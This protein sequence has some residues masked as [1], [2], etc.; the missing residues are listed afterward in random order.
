MLKNINFTRVDKKNNYLAYENNLQ[1]L[2]Y[3]IN[4]PFPE[5][6]EKELYAELLD[7]QNLILRG[8]DPHKEILSLMP[9]LKNIYGCS[10]TVY[11]CTEDEYESAEAINNS[12]FREL[13]VNKHLYHYNYFF[14]KQLVEYKYW[15]PENIKPEIKE[16]Y[17]I[18]SCDGLPNESNL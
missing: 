15:L 14:I 10:H 3:Y 6:L 18:I 1:K 16:N 5:K 4:T 12:V 17:Q 7:S 9:N 2:K 11:H 13:I 8:F